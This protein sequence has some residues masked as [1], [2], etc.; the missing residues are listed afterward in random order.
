MYPGAEIKHEYFSIILKGF[1]V[2]LKPS[3]LQSFQQDP[4][5]QE[6]GP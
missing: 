4:L 1:A 2:G 6:I 5:V 3:K